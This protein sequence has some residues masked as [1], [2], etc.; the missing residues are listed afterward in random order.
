MH[1]EHACIM[2][3]EHVVAGHGPAVA[4]SLSDEPLMSCH[5]LGDHMVV[6]FVRVESSR[7]LPFS[8]TK[9]LNVL[10]LF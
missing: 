2:H 3:G 10:C 6:E 4:V 1:G 8:E 7:G 9:C 5:R